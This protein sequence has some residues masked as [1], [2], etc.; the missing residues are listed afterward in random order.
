MA[1]ALG[2]NNV[3]YIIEENNVQ[4]VSIVMVFDLVGGYTGFAIN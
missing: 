4:G 3:I 1:D 2:Y